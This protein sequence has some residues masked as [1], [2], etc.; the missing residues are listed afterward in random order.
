M[1]TAFYYTRTDSQQ[2][3][4][5]P[6]TTFMVVVYHHEDT[7]P[8][9]E[10]HDPLHIEVHPT[11][12]LPLTNNDLADTNLLSSMGKAIS[13]AFR[14]KVLLRCLHAH[15]WDLTAVGKALNMSGCANVIRAIHDLGLVQVYKKAKADGFVRHG[16]R[17][18]RPK[19]AR[20][21]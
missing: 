16:G 2:Q 9:A 7:H 10:V 15:A 21:Q 8:I 11:E 1:E 19:K 13:Y 20:N 18:T 12:W 6:Y 3:A 17:R 14:Q 5:P 4:C